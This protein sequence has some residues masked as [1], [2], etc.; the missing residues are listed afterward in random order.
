[1]EQLFLVFNTY[2]VVF[3]GFVLFIGLTVGSF[4]NVVIFRL[5]I[6][7]EKEFKL[8][9]ETHFDTQIAHDNPLPPDSEKFN[10]AIPAS[11]CPKCGHKIKAW[12]NIPV[13]S[14]IL[15]KAKCSQCKTRI[16][17]RYPTIEALTGALS[18]AMAVYLGPTLAL[19]MAVIFLWS[20]IA[21]TFIDLDTML[22]PDQITLP[23]MW[24]G[25]LLSINSTFVTPEQAILGA[26]LGYLSLWSVY[27]VFKLVTGKEGMGYG[28]FKLLAALGAWTGYAYLPV[29]II[30][31]SFVGA[32][33]GIAM[34]MTKRTEK[35]QAI[36]FGPYLAI[37][38]L[39]TFF[40]GESIVSSYWQF[41]LS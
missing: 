7:M 20:L 18:V 36:P 25:L 39:I 21:L 38:G 33:I 17:A 31:S 24:L 14:W 16:S 15:L 27:W 40:F 4:L 12:E 22:L 3:Y 6:M 32:L 23:L 26:A 2:P 35:G 10:L 8:A 19:F 41:I 37:A 29:I 11:T 9:C 30:L 34:M 1:M 5:P 13:I 28:D